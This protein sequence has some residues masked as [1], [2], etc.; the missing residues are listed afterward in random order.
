MP[1][2][3]DNV[4]HACTNG[5][6]SVVTITGLVELWLFADD[7][8]VSVHGFYV[9]LLVVNLFVSYTRNG[10]PEYHPYQD[11]RMMGEIYL[12]SIS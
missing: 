8:I 10:C 3:K 6:A 4:A 11:A 2:R 7:T 12:S 9:A 1:A 5:F